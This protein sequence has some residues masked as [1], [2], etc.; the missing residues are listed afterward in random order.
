MDEMSGEYIDEQST[1]TVAK[2]GEK[3]GAK[4]NPWNRNVR[5]EE[6]NS[7]EDEKQDKIFFEMYQTYRYS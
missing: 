4:S 2:E 7:S 3:K 5:Y 1:D 6:D